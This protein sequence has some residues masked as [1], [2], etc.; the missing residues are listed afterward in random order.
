MQ[1]S[2]KKKLYEWKFII[3][4]SKLYENRMLNIFKGY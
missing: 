4:N 1:L 2:V 3:Q